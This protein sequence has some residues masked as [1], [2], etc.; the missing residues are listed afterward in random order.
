MTESLLKVRKR[1]AVEDPKGV[2]TQSTFDR[3][4]RD[5]FGPQAVRAAVSMSDSHT[6]S[7]R[8]VASSGIQRERRQR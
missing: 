8:G 6:P 1:I 5:Y 2:E 3:L 7:P 4:L